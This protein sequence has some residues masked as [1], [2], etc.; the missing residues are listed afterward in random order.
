M[1]KIIAWTLAAALLVG[2]CGGAG[3]SDASSSPSATTPSSTPASVPSWR[4]TVQSVS[5]VAVVSKTESDAAAVAANYAALAGAARCD[6]LVRSVVHA[7]AGPNE[8]VTRNSAALLIPQGAGCSGPFPLLAYARGTSRDRTRTL[9]DPT[10]KETGLLIGMFA[11][12]GVIVVATD[13]LGYAQSDYPYHPYL[14][15]RSEASSVIDSIRAAR[16]AL[17]SAGVATSGKIFLAGYSQGGHAALAAQREIERT[18]GSDITLTGAGP[19]SGPYDLALT[20]SAGASAAALPALVDESTLSPG[21][22]VRFQLADALADIAGAFTNLAPI[23]TL[24]ADQSVVDF[25]PV[26]PVLLCG[27]ARDLVV[28]FANTTAAAAAFSARGASATVVDID[29]E[30]A[31]NAFRPVPGTPASGLSDYH[32]RVVPP[33][34]F[35]VVRD[36]LIEPLR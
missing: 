11:A 16:S 12:R 20:F 28:P 34:C 35:Q 14:H 29:Q 26:A 15:A 5:D 21:D 24:L 32:N 13:Y 10:D 30:P 6:V 23:A 7:T 4:G 25:R 33:L 22:R 1:I 18:A 17:A 31:F 9:A 36:R 3:G 2:A 19:M 27:G 8:E